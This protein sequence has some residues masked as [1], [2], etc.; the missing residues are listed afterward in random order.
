MFSWFMDGVETQL[1]DGE[2]CI[3]MSSDGMGLMPFRRIS[4]RG[5]LQHGDTD[6]GFRY[7][8]RMITLVL[9]IFGDTEADM[10]AKRTELLALFSPTSTKGIFQW[11]FGTSIRQIEAVPLDGLSFSSKDRSGFSQKSAIVLKCNDPAWYDPDPKTVE[12]AASG[13]GGA[14]GG[15][16]P[17]DIPTDIGSS[18]VNA[19]VTINY[20]G[21]VDSFPNLIRITGPIDD[22]IITNLV[23]N[24]KLDFSG[25]TIAAGDYYDIDLRFGYKTVTSKTGVNKNSDL[26]SASDLTT[27]RII[28]A[29]EAPAGANSIQVTGSAVD[30]DTRVYIT[31]YDRFS[32]I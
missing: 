5:P 24:E 31:Y 7:D 12:L 4:D 22:P 29:P 26:T 8:P 27:F 1:D 30:A 32:G 10:W 25:T 13:G 2:L 15:A 3:L 20:T 23:T 11:K 28:A 18:G 16:I 9:Q 6:R 17:M 21:N 19:T 14:T